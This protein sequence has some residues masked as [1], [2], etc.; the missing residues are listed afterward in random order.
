MLHLVVD[1]N[2]VEGRKKYDYN[3]IKLK[4]NI[5]MKLF[6]MCVFFIAK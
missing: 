3:F 2:Q 4:M 5:V 1:Q 6:I